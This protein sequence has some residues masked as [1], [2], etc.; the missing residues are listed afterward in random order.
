ME[1]WKMSAVAAA[2]EIADGRL[3][4]E[5][6]VKSCLDRIE[7]RDD[8]VKAWVHLDKDH[9][10]AQARAAD[11]ALQFGNG[12]G[13]LHGVPVGI[14]DIIETHD[15]PT[16][17]NYVP[18]KGRH[19]HRDALCVSQ[20]RDAGAIILGKTVT[21]EL[22]T[23]SPGPTMNPHNPAHTPGGSS[24]GS[25]AAVADGQ[26]P[27]ALGTQTGGSVVR[28]GSFNGIWAL[29]PTFGLVARRG[30]TL[31]ADWLDTVGTYGR[32]AADVALLTQVMMAR[33]IDD[34]QSIPRSRPPLLGMCLQN[35]PRRP[36][37]AFMRTA[38]WDEAT[39][40]GQKALEDY[41]ASM[42]SDVTEVEMP[43][44][45]GEA[46]EWQRVLQLY[47]NAMHYGPL[48]D[49]HG[50]Q[51]TEV[52]RG[53]VIDGRNMTEAEYRHAVGQRERVA[54]ELWAGLEDYDAIL[55]LSSTGPAPEGLD[56]SRALAIS[57]DGST[58][59]GD[60]G[61][62]D[63]GGPTPTR[64]FRWTAEGGMELIPRGGFPSAGFGV[65][66]FGVSRD[67]SVVVGRTD[68][69][70]QTGVI[71]T[72]RFGRW[73]RLRDLLV[74]FGA[75]G[76]E[77]WELFEVLDVSD[78]GRVVT[79]WATPPG[80]IE[81]VAFRAVIPEPSTSLLLGLGLVGLGARRLPGRPGRP[82]RVGRPGR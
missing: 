4:S 1:P 63:A 8:A 42:G 15:M 79:G 55:C 62:F 69:G 13:P 9:A 35:P 52:L 49:A 41:A 78:D 32:S 36:R 68:S 82:G 20:L 25:G 72:A 40:A 24:S 54:A 57:A 19:T 77:G 26:V 81:S 66:P 71:W 6:L 53:N 67:G 50:E 27:L 29:K 73:I 21:T 16:Q 2:A 37:I 60:A 23:R 48:M 76:L 75:T 28:P 45:M 14:K 18:H 38:K 30:V 33:D 31:Q 51:M 46:W 58:I 34:P 64:A 5:D 59:V 74:A 39:P 70:F 56:W 12:T 65:T 47:G 61:L 11:L 3:T 80:Q 17:N 43:E 7:E 44:W 22:A 10:L